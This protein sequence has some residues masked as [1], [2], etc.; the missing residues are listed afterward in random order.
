MQYLKNFREI[1]R[2]NILQIA[3]N[4]ASNRQKNNHYVVIYIQTFQFPE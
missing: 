1:F 4:C 3:N 2:A